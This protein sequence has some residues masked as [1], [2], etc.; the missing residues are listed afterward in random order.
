[1]RRYSIRTNS[2]EEHER[3]MKVL[4]EHDVKD[5]HS[6]SAL[7]CFTI[8]SF[9]CEKSEWK[10]IKKELGLEIDIT[11]VKFKED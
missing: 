11:Y 2:V 3:S 8:I 4:G 7:V 5:I 1:M 10:K 9:K 6:M